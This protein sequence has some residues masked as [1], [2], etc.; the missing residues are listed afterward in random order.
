MKTLKYL[1]QIVL[2]IFVITSC[3]K[4]NDEVT[5][6]VPGYF[7]LAELNNNES[8]SL[9]IAKS[10][11]TSSYEFGDLRASKEF[12]FL[13]TNGGDE[14]IF[15]ITLSTDN[16]QFTIRPSQVDKLYG[17]TLN[18][19]A[20]NTGI[21]PILTLGINHGTNLN[22]VGYVDLLPM[23]VNT[24]VL[25]ITGQTIDNG[26]TI[27]ISN[28]FDISVNAKVMDIE[29]YE[30][31]NK[32]NMENRSKSI[33]TTLGGL[34]FITY[35]SIYDTSMIHIKNIGNV[36]I[37]LYY[38]DILGVQDNHILLL[39]SDSVSLMPSYIFT[40]IVLDSKGTITENSRISLGNDGK[41]YFCFIK[42]NHQ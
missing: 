18:S 17:G 11:S 24:S 29:L 20:E 14:P 37:D 33:A 41:G 42:D 27:E 12:F 35:Y 30:G 25:T 15:N 31:S 32:I 23:G 13:L 8:L 9:R 10:T 6:K 2:L 22:G 19:N 1:G 21:I 36:D 26:D 28:S 7:V 3:K 40:A 4:N 34:G 38:G 39:Q 5:K 16:S